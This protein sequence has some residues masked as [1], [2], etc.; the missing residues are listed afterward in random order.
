M[1]IGD[2]QF[3]NLS[4]YMVPINLLTDVIFPKSLDCNLKVT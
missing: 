3:L 4:D 2:N 1:N